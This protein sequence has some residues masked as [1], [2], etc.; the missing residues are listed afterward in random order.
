VNTPTA[1]Q[2]P[3]SQWDDIRLQGHLEARWATWCDG[4][5]LTTQPDGSTALRGHVVDQSALHGV[6]ARRRDLGVP[7]ISLTQI[8]AHPRLSPQPPATPTDQE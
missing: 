1:H 6:L 5:T 8:P 7:L 4:M 2:P 3:D